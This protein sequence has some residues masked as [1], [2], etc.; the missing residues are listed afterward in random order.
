MSPD[1]RILRSQRQR[2]IALIAVLASLSLL[3][4]LALGVLELTRHRDRLGHRSAQVIVEQERLDSA[5]RLA[6]L[7]LT[8]PNPVNVLTSPLTV[9]VLDE[10]VSVAIEF[11][12][13][14]VDLNFAD[15]ELLAAVL[16]AHGISSHEADRLAA[17]IVDW[18]D[19]DDDLSPQGAERAEYRAVGV[20]AGPRN[21]PFET[22]SELRNVL[23]F[24]DLSPSVLASFTVY[25]HAEFPRVAQASD[26]VTR[27]VA[28]LNP[29]AYPAN[30]ALATSDAVLSPAK[31]AGEAVRLRAC[32]KS[33]FDQ[34]CRESIVLFTGNVSD[35]VLVFAWSSV[36]DA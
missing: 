26:S 21:G 8:D 13:S 17:R 14:R 22:I 36:F 25:S 5:I 23:G 35:P 4:V 16:G 19:A 24:G 28:R 7:R 3:F 6:I 18:R 11:E 1:S 29:T 15:G 30:A 31:L 32:S 27:A 12:A 10:Q 34:L 20:R 33:S 9:E 2:G